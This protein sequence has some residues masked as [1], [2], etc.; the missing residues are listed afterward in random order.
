MSRFHVS[1]AIRCFAL[2]SSIRDHYVARLFT[3]IW[4]CFPL[5]FCSALCYGFLVLLKSVD[6]FCFLLSKSWI[7]SWIGSCTRRDSMCLMC[8]FHLDSMCMMCRFPL[9]S[10]YMICHSSFDSTCTFS[11]SCFGF[12]DPAS[13]PGWDLHLS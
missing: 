9:V 4:L 5:C 12:I 2:R 6:S 10:K 7:G 11:V 13:D 3:I 1:M 8:V